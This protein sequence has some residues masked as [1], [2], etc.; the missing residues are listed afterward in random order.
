[1]SFILE[2]NFFNRTKGFPLED[3]NFAGFSFG[4]NLEKFDSFGII[5][6]S[7]PMYVRVYPLRNGCQ[8][9][10]IISEDGD[11]ANLDADIRDKEYPKVAWGFSAYL[12]D[13]FNV[14]IDGN[15]HNKK[16]NNYIMGS[17]EDVDFFID[18]ACAKKQYFDLLWNDYVRYHSGIKYRKITEKRKRISFLK[19]HLED[20]KQLW[21]QTDPILKNYLLSSVNPKTG[22]L[23]YN[24]IV[25]ITKDYHN[26]I[27]KQK[28][29]IH[30]RWIYNLIDYIKKNII[31]ILS[32]I[33]RFIKISL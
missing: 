28:N 5:S 16:H 17:D 32:V 23:L 14:I 3:I 21:K 29:K 1:M 15:I 20:E 26:E 30:F 13:C 2:Q 24:F 6:N 22:A 25:D 31:R 33:W 7:Y 18:E 12:F 8:D 10:H 19:Q 4:P 11:Y 9:G 27:K